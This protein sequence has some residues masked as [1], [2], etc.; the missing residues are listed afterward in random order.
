MIDRLTA[1]HPN[2][3]IILMVMNPAVAHTGRNRPGLAAYN[4]MY[5][6]VARERNFQLIDHFPVWENIL[7]TDPALF[8]HYV[9]DAIH[10][11]REG[12]LKVITPTLITALGLQPGRPE[13]SQDAPCWKYLFRGSM[14]VDKNWEVTR[15][16]FNQ[17]WTKHFELQDTDQNL[18]LLPAEYG[19]AGL[20]KLFDANQDGQIVPEEYQR[21]YAPHFDSRDL[22]KDDVLSRSEYLLENGRKK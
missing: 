12:A 17:F 15:E 20:F 3:E 6:D 16:E 19:P 11:V 18:E 9:P 21:I 14:D 7:N 4:Q 5:R 13:L 8:I 1:A 22:N 2:C 10:P